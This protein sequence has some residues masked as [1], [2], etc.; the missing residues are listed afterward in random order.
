MYTRPP[1]TTRKPEGLGYKRHGVWELLTFFRIF[2]LEALA[3]LLIG[4]FRLIY[5]AVL[6]QSS[7]GNYAL[8]SEDVLL[9]SSRGNYAKMGNVLKKNA[10][11]SPRGNVKKH[12][13]KHAKL[14]KL[15][16]S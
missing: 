5:Q 16:N 4:V 8:I 14:A 12:V 15:S 11:V 6:L 13:E 9:Q 3:V 7:R 10:R 2:D 1:W